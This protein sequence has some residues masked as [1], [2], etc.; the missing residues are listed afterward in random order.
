[1]MSAITDPDAFLAL[2]ARMKRSATAPMVPHLT[3]P[4]TRPGWVGK[5]A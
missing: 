3:N 4:G 2:Q 5:Q 1:M